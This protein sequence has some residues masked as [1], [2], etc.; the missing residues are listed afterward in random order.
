MQNLKDQIEQ[1][2]QTMNQSFYTGHDQLHGLESQIVAEYE[3]LN[4]HIDNVKTIAGTMHHDTLKNLT[5]LARTLGAY[6]AKIPPP[7]Q[8]Q[9]MTDSPRMLRSQEIANGV[10]DQVFGRRVA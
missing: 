10:A 6:P 8:Q 1:L 3:A 5:E 2:R 7:L 4:K 9:P